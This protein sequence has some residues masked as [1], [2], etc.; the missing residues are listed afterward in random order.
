MSTTQTL[1][2]MPPIGQPESFYVKAVHD[3]DRAGDV[4]AREA[5]KVGQYITLANDPHLSWEEKLKYFCHALRRHCVPPP[6]A[7]EPVWIF[8]RSLANLVKQN[9]GQ[10]ALRVASSEDDLYATRINMG[11]SREQIDNEAEAFFGRLVP[12]ECPEWFNEDDYRQLKLLRD[13]WI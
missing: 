3:A 2:P 4:H 5:F 9:A 10:E 11:Q 6:L 1:P 7:E 12:T 8:Y 13:Q